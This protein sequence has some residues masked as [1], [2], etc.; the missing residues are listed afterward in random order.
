MHGNLPYEKLEDKVPLICGSFT[1]WRYRKM[2]PLHEFTMII[3]KNRADLMEV[4]KKQGEIRQRLKSQDEF[5]EY[6]HAIMKCL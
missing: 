2:I 5:N 1:G 3:D 6:E 4:G